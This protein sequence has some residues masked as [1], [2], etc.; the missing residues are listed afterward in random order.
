MFQEFLQGQLRRRLPGEVVG[1]YRRA[2]DWFNGAGY[3]AE[4][5]EYALL[6]GDIQRTIELIVPQ[7][8]QEM[9]AGRMPRVND[10]IGRIPEQDRNANS[11]LLKANA[12]ALYHMNRPD[13]AA[14]ITDQ[15]ERLEGAD[16]PNVRL[17]R[18]GISICRDDIEPILGHL[19][20]CP[21]DMSRFDLGTVNNIRGYAQTELARYDEAR[22]S[23]ALARS[24]H[25]AMGSSF[26]VV[27]ADC[28]LG[29]MDLAHGNLDACYGRFSEPDNRPRSAETYVAPVPAVMRGLVLYEWNHPAEAAPLLRANVPLLEQVGHIKLL[30]LGCIA[31]GKLALRGG[32]WDRL[33]HHFD[34]C[35]ELGAARGA[36]LD[37]LK[38]LVESER[39]RILA[40]GG[41]LNDA[42]HRAQ[43]LHVDPDAPAPRPSGHWERVACLRLLTW[44]RLQVAGGSPVRALPMLRQLQSLAQ[45]ARR[46]RRLLECLLVEI[47]AHRAMR[48]EPAAGRILQEALRLG[49]PGRQVMAFLDE[50]TRLHDALR[51]AEMP[52]ED[53]LAHFLKLL[54]DALPDAAAGSTG[55]L[56]SAHAM[57]REDFSAREREILRHVAAGHSNSVIGDQ[58][59]ISENTVKWHLKNLFQK[60][61][62]RNR[63]AAVAAA[64]RMHWIL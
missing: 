55:T 45:N 10:W 29:L 12:T 6:S 11:S 34:H 53:A 31:L 13:E 60:L 59:Q 47:S 36:H 20:A 62:V 7:M 4:A 14:R 39:V 38:S 22:A 9:M 63:T 30:T 50:G 33:H 35:L 23:L 19:A 56:P 24:H 32:D 5:V 3:A 21:T 16:N 51:A 15:L 52:H 61:E 57:P 42:L 18:A 54:R 58:L 37:R 1:L 17:L 43:S 40:A 25:S 27:Y 46:S 2:A 8:Q 64:R 41:Q 26:G 44:C 28:F 48:D 49:A